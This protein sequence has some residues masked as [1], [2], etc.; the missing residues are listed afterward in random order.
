MDFWLMVWQEKCP[1]IVMLTKEVEGK[2][3]CV[4]FMYNCC[5]ANVKWKFYLKNTLCVYRLFSWLKLLVE[6]SCASCLYSLLSGTN[7]FVFLCF[8]KKKFIDIAQRCLKTRQAIHVYNMLSRLRCIYFVIW[9]KYAAQVSSVLAKRWGTFD[10]LRISS[11]HYET[12]SIP[13]F[14]ERTSHSCHSWW[15]VRAVYNVFGS[16][17]PPNV[18]R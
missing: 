14:M 7:R 4:H 18:Y 5:A 1:L 13:S 10:A 15:G 17:R 6:V 12:S 3:V 2:K 8:D 16:Y 11:C 9:L